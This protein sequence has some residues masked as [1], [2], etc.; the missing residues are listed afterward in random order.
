MNSK[1]SKLRTEMAKNQEK[2][3]RLEMRN[4]ELEQQIREL[5]DLEIIGMVR[6][7]GLSVEE[8]AGILRSAM[9][10]RGDI[11]NGH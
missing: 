8:F 5:E 3:S 1:I 6:D 2:I 4:C 7:Q 10:N 9:T 11:E